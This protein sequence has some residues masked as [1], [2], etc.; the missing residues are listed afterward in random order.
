MFSVLHR[1]QISAESPDPRVRDVI[2]AQFGRNLIS[3]VP[4]LSEW[5]LIVMA[6][7][8]GIVGMLVMRRRKVTA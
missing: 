5:G 4:T 2:L 6:G 8:L 1:Q 3:N 7:L